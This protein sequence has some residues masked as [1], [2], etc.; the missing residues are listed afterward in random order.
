MAKAHGCIFIQ[1]SK[2]VEMNEQTNWMS[3]EQVAVFIGV[4]KETIYRLLE[5]KKIP[6]HR[7]GKL[8]RFDP[9]EVSKAVKRGKLK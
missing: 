2:E 4:S 8:H 3:V 5:K 6:S 9:Q 1:A 7:V